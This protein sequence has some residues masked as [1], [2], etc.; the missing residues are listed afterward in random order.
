MVP[1]SS[2]GILSLFVPVLTLLLAIPV[3]IMKKG[4]S[5]G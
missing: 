3:T 4:S 5:N 1:A 2:Q